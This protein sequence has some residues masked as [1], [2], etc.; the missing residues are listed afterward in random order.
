MNFGS[1]FL[2]KNLGR[3][4]GGG[5]GAWQAAG[6]GGGGQAEAGTDPEKK[7]TQ[8]R[9]CFCEGGRGGF[10]PQNFWEGGGGEEGGGGGRA[11]HRPSQKQCF[12]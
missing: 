10:G 5:G 2:K 4:E 1:F 8:G 12:T 9:L 11:R 7:Q 3:R 6:G